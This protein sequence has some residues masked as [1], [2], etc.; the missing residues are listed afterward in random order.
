LP[1]E[2]NSHWQ[3]PSA[4]NRT[5]HLFRT[6][7]QAQQAKK[8]KSPVPNWKHGKQKK[9]EAKRWRGG[10]K[11]ERSYPYHLHINHFCYSSSSFISA[12]FSI[13]DQQKKMSNS[14]ENAWENK[15]EFESKV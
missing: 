11:R 12:T 15:L 5:H 6:R 4:E 14:E 13:I 7:I 1:Y 3:P 2:G 9:S 10:L 8:M